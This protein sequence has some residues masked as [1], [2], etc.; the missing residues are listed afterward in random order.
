MSTKKTIVAIVIILAAAALMVVLALVIRNKPNS[1]NDNRGQQSQSTNSGNSVD[2]GNAGSVD[3]GSSSSQSV[4]SFPISSTN[5]MTI[6][7]PTQ[8]SYTLPDPTQS[9]GT[10]STDT[11]QSSSSSV[12]T[13]S[14][15]VQWTETAASGEYYLNTDGIYSRLEA[16]R[17]GEMSVQYRLNDK[18]KVIAIT[19]TGYY[20][21]EDGTFIHSDYLSETE[22]ARWTETEASG[23]YY[24]NSS[25]VYS[26]INAV[27]G[28]DTVNEYTINDK[29][30]VVAKTD[31]DYY[32]LEDGSFIHAD[33]LSEEEIK[34]SDLPDYTSTSTNGYTIER[35]N[36]ITYVDGIMIANKTYT[37]P[38]N[39]NPGTKPDAYDAF[40]E[41]QSAAE[42][43][44]ISLF[45]VSGF[46]S[47]DDQAAIYARY[48]DSDGE[49][50]AD[51]YSSRP[52]HS[53][54][55]TG[56]TFDLNSLDESFAYTPEGIWLA[57]NCAEYGFIIRYPEGK[58]AYTGYTYEPWHVRY[59]GTE[60]AEAITASGLSLEEYYG[61]S[62]D[63]SLS[64][65]G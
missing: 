34:L 17:Q 32:K 13:E 11:T 26:R 15:T 36:G 14:P 45:I 9:S 55:Q 49:E 59:V 28:S 1:G 25:G 16:H 57:E 63:Y 5:S 24:V 7:D 42:A 12:P 3:S 6:P 37:L 10:S 39:Y 60:K 31:T 22:A 54:H 18:V 40:L 58:D 51:T 47:Y 65:N 20:K 23:E 4:Y 35:V 61:I 41:M 43:D 50:L 33:Y 46:R 52:G 8:S 44:G 64:G 48:A 19:D 21:L 2:I 30:T 29:V 62:S 27:Q 38:R 53:D 56:Y